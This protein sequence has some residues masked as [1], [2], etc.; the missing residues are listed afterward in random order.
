MDDL[1]RR[2]Y[3]VGLEA[4]TGC[5]G[6]G[7]V[8]CVTFLAA[9]K[10]T[11]VAVST[12]LS[13]VASTTTRSPT[14]GM[15]VP[16]GLPFSLKRVCLLI[17]TSTVVPFVVLISRCFWS[18]T[19]TV[20]STCWPGPWAKAVVAAKIMMMANNNRNMVNLFSLNRNQ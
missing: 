1:H 2:S 13:L 11:S 9:E 8:C 16:L 6:A 17:C 7:V 12:L 3:W 14:A 4:G 15:L 10:W 5:V 20:P 18:M 19:V